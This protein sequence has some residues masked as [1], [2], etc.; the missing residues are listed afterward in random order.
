MRILDR[1]DIA[2]FEDGDFKFKFQKQNTDILNEYSK[3]VIGDRPVLSFNLNVNGKEIHRFNGGIKVEIPYELSAGEN[4]NQL[5]LY[6]V[7]ESGQLSQVKNSRYKQ[8]EEWPGDKPRIEGLIN[9][10]GT[11]AVGYKTISHTDVFGWYEPPASFVLARGIMNDINGLFMPKASITRS[12]LAFFL[13]N[14]GGE[15]ME[16][17]NSTFIDVPK[18]HPYM[19]SIDWAYG[20]GLIKGY[21]DGTF[22]PDQVITRQELAVMLNRYTQIIGKSHMPRINKQITFK[23]N[24]KISPFAKESVSSLQQADVIGG[25]GNGY[26][27]P[28]DNV[29]RAE[30]AKMIQAVMD[31][32]I[33]GKTRFIPMN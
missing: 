24:N 17:L 7:E 29:T 12:D 1:K 13:S 5:A 18:D 21:E 33:D 23:D 14:M 6:R 10:L 27:V 28:G 19:K 9:E 31:G 32:I 16:S 30:C 11:Y 25:R 3:A 20:A 22:K 2:S 8:N 15:N 4:E 26:F